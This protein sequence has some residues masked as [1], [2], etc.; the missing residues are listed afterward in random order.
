MNYIQ[1]ELRE[2]SGG[3]KYIIPKEMSGKFTQLEDKVQEH[4]LEATCQKYIDHFEEEFEQFRVTDLDK[5]TLYVKTE[6]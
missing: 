5:V 3:N 4:L 1:V 6:K 2:D